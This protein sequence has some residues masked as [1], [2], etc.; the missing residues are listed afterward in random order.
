MAIVFADRVKVRA[1]STGTGTFT[2][3]TPTP[4]FQS[5]DAVGNG[6][7]CYYGIEDH[8]GN[9]EVGVGT[10]TAIGSTLSRDTVISSSN[11]NLLVDFPAGGKSVFTTLPSS[12]AANIISSTTFAFRD[13]AVSG[14]TTV[15]AD[16]TADTLTL[17]AGTGITI[18]TDAPSDA[19]TINSDLGNLSIVGN[20]II[21]NDADQGIIIAPGG[22]SASYVQVPGNA[23]SATT[24]LRIGNAAAGGIEILGDKI[25]YA[26]D[27]T[28]S[29]QDATTCL[30]GV[31]TVIYTGTDQFTFSLKLFVMVQGVEDGGGPGPD[32]QACDIIA[33]RGW[34]DNIIHLMAYGVTYSGVA[35]LA[36]FDA[37]WNVT[38]NRIEITCVPTS[39]T[40]SVTASVH[41]IEMTSNIG[42]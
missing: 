14:Q 35:P 24:A 27:I 37:Q 36:T 1:Y 11:L 31:D 19:I 9:W 2:L 12:V 20:V 3:E 18:T 25:V 26:G 29:Y 30:A 38:S 32:T 23:E 6:N 15:V 42:A 17:I 34:N 22:E 13:I 10:Y 7:E 28:Q 41:A 33:V 8:A 5:F 40:S 16:S 21:N 4:G 39:A